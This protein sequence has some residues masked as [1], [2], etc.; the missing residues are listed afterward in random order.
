MVTNDF[1]LPILIILGIV[2]II[3]LYIFEKKELLISFPGKNKEPLK[4]NIVDLMRKKGLKARKIGTGICVEKYSILTLT[5]A[6]LYLKQDGKQ[7]K[8][9]GGC[10]VS[11]FGWILLFALFFWWSFG[12]ATIIVAIILDF[13]SKNFAQK[14]LL[15]IL[16]ELKINGK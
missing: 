5:S 13:N 1:F 3:A 10:N 6:N 14:T 16:K 2:F 12:I 15:P 11:I 9:Y 8:V 4:E 7:V